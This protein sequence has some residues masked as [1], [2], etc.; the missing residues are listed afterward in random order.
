MI[1][2]GKAFY[3]KVFDNPTEFPIDADL[4]DLLYVASEAYETKTGK[5]YKHVP[6]STYETGWNKKNWGENAVRFA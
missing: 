4:E 2:E 1:A 3:E 5:V 6:R